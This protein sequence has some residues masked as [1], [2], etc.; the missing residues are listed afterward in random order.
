[1]SIIPVTTVRGTTLAVSYDTE[2]SEVLLSDDAHPEEPPYR[3]T[4]PEFQSLMA[5]GRRIGAILAGIVR[6]PVAAQ[7]TMAERA[8]QLAVLMARIPSDSTPAARGG[9]R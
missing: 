7:A 5:D 9:R 3:F 1:M 8:E 2:L 4:V 6:N